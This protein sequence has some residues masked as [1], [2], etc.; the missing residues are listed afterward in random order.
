MH[1]FPKNVDTIVVGHH[2]IFVS[3]PFYKNLSLFFKLFVKKRVKP[4]KFWKISWLP[5][6]IGL[7]PVH[8]PGELVSFWKILAFW[9]KKGQILQTF[10]QNTKVKPWKFWKISWN[11]PTSGGNRTTSGRN[12]RFSGI[13]PLLDPIFTSFLP[14]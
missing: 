11:R 6:E 13:F 7:L 9:A 5:A 12:P 2:L 4:W 14:K 3:S 8:F 1:F 10:C